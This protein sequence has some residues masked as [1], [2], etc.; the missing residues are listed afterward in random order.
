MEGI[1]AYGARAD[2]AWRFNSSA[3]KIF[4][5][6][7]GPG[8]PAASRRDE[9]VSIVHALQGFD[10]IEDV[11]ALGFRRAFFDGMDSAGLCPNRLAAVFWTI[12]SAGF[13]CST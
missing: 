12:R 13:G 4:L 6:G 9:W 2:C 10:S 1:F 5:G 11:C 7:A 3:R 8:P